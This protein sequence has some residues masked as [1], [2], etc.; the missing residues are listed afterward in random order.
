MTRYILKRIAFMIVTLLVISAGTFWMMHTVPGNPL[1]TKA[2]KNL[3][4]Q[5]LDA[6]M[7]KYK[8]DRPIREQYLAFL[9][10]A[11]K[12]DFGESIIY[13]GQKVV[14]TI[15]KTAPVSGKL[16]FIALLIG[17]T[18][19]VTFGFIAALNRGKWPDY[20]VIAISMLGVTIPSFVMA[21]LLQYFL[22][23]KF[24]LFPITYKATNWKS[25]VMPIMALSFGTIAT[26]ARYMRSSVLEVVNSD[27]ILT[28]KA[29]GVGKMGVILKHILKNAMI[30]AITILGPQIT[31]V[32]GGSF[33][34]EKIF[35][36]PGLGFFLVKSIPDRDY[37][38]IIATTVLFAF[39]FVVSQL[40]VDIVYGLI[41]PRIKV[42]D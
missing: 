31:G 13:P 25:M 12:G 38:M 8:L 41:D 10:N 21:A 3:P 24:K 18:L 26:Y 20:L 11:V 23:N 35:N 15:K 30:P 29:K 7:K 34:I 9:Q 32:F 4:P 5:V 17:F 33:V 27:Y 6:F 14:D 1:L 42:A 19:G 22:G 2:Q 36:I 37:P 40:V 28:A 39:L 16:G